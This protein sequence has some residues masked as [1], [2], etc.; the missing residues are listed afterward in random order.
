[1]KRRTYFVLGRGWVAQYRLL[2][3]WLDCYGVN[4]HPSAASAWAM[5]ELHKRE[6][7]L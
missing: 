3:W 1:M 5:C 6:C 4:V 7:W 2:W